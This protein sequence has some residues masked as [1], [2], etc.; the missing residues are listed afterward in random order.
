M[1][2]RQTVFIVAALPLFTA[3][4]FAQG[5]TLNDAQTTLRNCTYETC[6]L[7]LSTRVL[8]GVTVSRGLNGPHEDFGVAGGVLRRAVSAVPA[9]RSEAEAG[10]RRYVRGG[11]FGIV[12][13][14]ASAGLAL[15]ASRQEN[16]D[17]RNRNLL[18]G[19]GVMAGVG[20][21]GSTQI[22]RGDESYSRAIWLYNKEIPR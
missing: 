4:L 6:A 8:S 16:S 3:A 1:L 17:S 20:L 7:R 19:A 22:A 13:T 9:A 21:Y 2:T 10:H 14:V 18:I 12:G 5:P 11:I 15:L